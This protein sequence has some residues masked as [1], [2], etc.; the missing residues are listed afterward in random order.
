MRYWVMMT[1][2]L[3]HYR[4][5]RGFTQVAL[6]VKADLDETTVRRLESG[7]LRRCEDA[8][9]MRLARELK[10]D[11][12]D[13][14]YPERDLKA[15]RGDPAYQ[16]ARDRGMQPLTPIDLR[17]PEEA[18]TGPAMRMV[19]REVRLGFDKP[20]IELDGEVHKVLGFAAMHDC[21]LHYEQL[22]ELFVVTGT[23]RELRPIPVDVGELLGAELGRGAAYARIRRDISGLGEHGEDQPLQTTVFAPSGADG[24]RLNHCFRQG[25]PVKVKVT[26]VVRHTDDPR[27]GF[28]RLAEPG[29]WPWAFVVLAIY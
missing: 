27:R 8:S 16:A 7:K 6:A 18:L 15:G 9:L 11:K 23:I 13:L 22:E 12:K 21:E 5:E 2:R 3:R 1:G 4:D 28:P 17:A 29:V 26:I 14:A 25:I 24:D 20:T 10:C 19:Q